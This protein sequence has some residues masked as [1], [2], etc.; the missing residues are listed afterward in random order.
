MTLDVAFHQGLIVLAITR[1]A[2]IIH[3]VPAHTVT[4][5]EIFAI[6]CALR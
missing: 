4:M 6:L 2:L 3:A 5:T 1:I